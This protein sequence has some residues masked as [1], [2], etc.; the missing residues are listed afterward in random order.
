L[1]EAYRSAAQ[2]NYNASDIRQHRPGAVENILARTFF[3]KDSLFDN[4]SVAPG[5]R[6]HN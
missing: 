1:A 2:N 5:L 6:N 3:R 4:R